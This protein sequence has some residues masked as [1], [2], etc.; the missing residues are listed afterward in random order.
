MVAIMCMHMYRETVQQ[1]VQGLCDRHFMT[2]KCEVTGK[3]FKNGF[4]WCLMNVRH[5]LLSVGGAI[6]LTV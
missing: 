3:N 6:M 2:V 1:F 4:G 5:V